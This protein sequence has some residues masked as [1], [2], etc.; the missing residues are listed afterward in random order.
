MKYHINIYS[1]N[2]N[3]YCIDNCIDN[4]LVLIIYTF[5][6]IQARASEKTGALRHAFRGRDKN[7]QGHLVGM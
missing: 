1:T 6:S 3:I 7:Q 5:I 4:H 2:T